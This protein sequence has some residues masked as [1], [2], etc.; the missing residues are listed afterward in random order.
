MRLSIVSIGDYHYLAFNDGQQTSVLCDAETGKGIRCTSQG[1]INLLFG[2]NCDAP[3][4]FRYLDDVQYPNKLN[5][6]IGNAYCTLTDGDM[7]MTLRLEFGDYVASH[8]DRLIPVNSEGSYLM[9][10]WEVNEQ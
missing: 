9:P 2:A 6:T 8:H 1:V 3:I 4:T 5:A 10:E 7:E